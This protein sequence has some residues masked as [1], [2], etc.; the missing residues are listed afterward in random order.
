MSIIMPSYKSRRF[1][2]NSI[3]SVISQ[4]YENW[5]MIIVDDM[6]P[7]DS[8]KIIQKYVNIDPRIQLIPLN[9]NSGPAIAR[10]IGIE[11]AKGKY[12]AFLD[13]DDIWLPV[14]LEKQIHFMRDNQL[15]LT[16]GSY[17]T[18]DENGRRM[19]TRNA[20]PYISYNDML[21]SNHIGNLTGMYDAEKLGKYYM[22]NVGH[23]DYTLWLKILRDVGATKGM[24]DPLAEYR[25]L[26]GSVS[27]NKIKAAQW[28]WAIY[29]DVL[30]L[31]IYKRIYYI[32]WYLYY[33]LRKHLVL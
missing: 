7:D 14:K 11:N 19:G 27:S 1:I 9:K 13:S 28:Q 20:K 2:S 31:N 29:R 16:Y 23:E 24:V 12:I 18:I 32:S 15:V 30:K 4:T 6:S 25:I 3:N 10:N 5:E 21:K 17:Y 22:D 8:N 26:K 33:G